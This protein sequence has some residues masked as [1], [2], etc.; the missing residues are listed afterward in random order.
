MIEAGDIMYVTVRGLLHGQRTINTFFFYAPNDSAGVEEVD[1]ASDFLIAWLAAHG[2]AYAAPLSNEFTNGTVRCQL[3]RPNGTTVPNRWTYVELPLDE[4]TGLVVESS[5]PSVCAA[6][7]RRRTA[8]AGRENR[9]RFYIPA[10]PVTYERDSTL[11]PAAY[12]TL[13]DAFAPIALT[14]ITTDDVDWKP[15][16]TNS[17][18]HTRIV[19]VTSVILDDVLR[20][21]RRREVRVGE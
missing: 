16:I 12:D 11:F 3:L 9:G 2:S 17:P 5:L 21:Q 13:T 18:S 6:V 1:A 19:E 14:E 4:P 20:V 8:L 15:C 7:M 10:L